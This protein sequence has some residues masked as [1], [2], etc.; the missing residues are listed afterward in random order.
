MML[1]EVLAHLHNWF[2]KDV[3]SGS[4]VVADGKINLSEGQIGQYFRIIGS[5][6]NDGL[7]KIGE[8]SLVDEE[9][10]G[11]VQLLAVP[12]AVVE[13][14]EEIGAWCEKN[15]DAL[16]SPY[17]S[18]SFGGYSYSKSADSVGGSGAPLGWQYQFRSRLNTWKKLA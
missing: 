17:T 16:S 13:L 7:H 1:E 8:G 3:I 6:F 18:E 2:V 11:T 12:K 9:F 10:E 4:F 14:A 5:V 15:A